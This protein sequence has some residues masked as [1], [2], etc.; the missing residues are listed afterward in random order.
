MFSIIIGLDV[1]KAVTD[2]N[3]DSTPSQIRRLAFDEANILMSETDTDII[4]ES[5]TFN[6][7]KNR[8][9]EDH[10]TFFRTAYKLD[11]S[12]LGVVNYDI[13]KAIKF[14]ANKESDTNYV[15]V[16]T[17]SVSN[18]SEIVTE[19][20]IIL[21]PSD[22]LSKIEKARETYKNRRLSSFEDAIM[23]TLFIS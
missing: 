3:I 23:T 18:F 10:I 14:V 17:D 21:K 22:F 12:A 2:K 1:I 19:R 11:E 8:L 13:Y 4:I 9:N 6:S 15:I 16:L 7:V 5:L 20:C